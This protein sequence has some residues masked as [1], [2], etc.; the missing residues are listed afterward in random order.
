MRREP[1][2]I[3]KSLTAEE[4]RAIKKMLGEQRLSFTDEQDRFLKHL[5]N[6]ESDRLDLMLDAY[7]YGYLEGQ[8]LDRSKK[9]I[10]AT[11]V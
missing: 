4:Y 2:Q 6:E 3:S 7:F 11:M 1:I 8:R 10:V 9:Q 5:H